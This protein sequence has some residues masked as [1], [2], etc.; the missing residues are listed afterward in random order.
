MSANWEQISAGV[1]KLNPDLL[2]KQKHQQAKTNV[3]TTETPVT[4]DNTTITN[5]TLLLPLLQ[6]LQH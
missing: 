5:P 6:W 2:E 1:P 3:T 4:T